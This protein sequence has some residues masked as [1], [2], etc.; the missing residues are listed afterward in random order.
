MRYMGKVFGLLLAFATLPEKSRRDF[1]T[2]LN[3]FMMMSPAQRRRVIAEWQ[4][5]AGERAG[6]PDEPVSGH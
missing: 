3:E 6:Q 4:H 1:L 2:R 5:A